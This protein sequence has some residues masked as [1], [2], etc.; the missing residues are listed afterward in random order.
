MSREDEKS[1]S[2]GLWSDTAVAYWTTTQIVFLGVYLG[3]S[4]LGKSRHNDHFH[5]PH[6]SDWASAFTNW[7][8]QWYLRIA[9]DGYSYD[10]NQMSSV[11][12]FPAFPLMGRFLAQATG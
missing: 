1:T 9:R 7:D 8:G 12:F 3:H 6:R 5:T 2:C 4:Y 11:A 10:P